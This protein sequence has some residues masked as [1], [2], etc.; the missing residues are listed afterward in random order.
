MYAATAGYEP[1]ADSGFRPEITVVIPAKNEGEVIESVV[2]TGC[3]ILRGRGSETV[4]AD[5]DSLTVP[6]RIPMLRKHGRC[7]AQYVRPLPHPQA[8]W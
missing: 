7:L 5:R 6:A 1:E 2:R 8:A 4:V 3:G